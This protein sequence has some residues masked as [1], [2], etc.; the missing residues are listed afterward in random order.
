MIC[1]N[2]TCSADLARQRFGPAPGFCSR[3]CQVAALRNRGRH[4][5]RITLDMDTVHL[6][7]HHHRTR[8]GDDTTIAEIL[9][10]IVDI[11]TDRILRD[12]AP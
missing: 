7:E 11:E 1:A 5:V 2:P 6:L 9:A 8:L 3:R 10:D 4:T 12:T